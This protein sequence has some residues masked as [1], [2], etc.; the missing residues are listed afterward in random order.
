MAYACNRHKQRSRVA[1]GLTTAVLTLL[2]AAP[3][4]AV[5]TTA[6]LGVSATV[7]ANCTITT[8]AVSFGRYESLQANATAPLNAAGTVSIAC[9]K[10]S[11]PRIAMDLGQNPSGGKRYMALVAAGGPASTLHYELYQPATAAP[12]AGCIFPGAAAWGSAAT[13]AFV[14]RAASGR[15]PRTYSI[16]GTV[17][18]GQAVRMGSYADTVVATV[19]F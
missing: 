17:P 19:N 12:G 4:R 18:A 8:S 10:G 7:N 6:V 11:A 15:A 13:Q 2:V 14:P 3:P 1:T 5:G 9:S 16:C